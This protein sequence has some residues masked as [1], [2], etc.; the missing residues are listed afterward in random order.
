VK[1]LKK[2]LLSGTLAGVVLAAAGPAMADLTA[3]YEGMVSGTL[4][5]NL[6]GDGMSGMGNYYIGASQFDKNLSTAPHTTQNPAVLF[7][8]F[9][10]DL[11]QE[12]S[13]G[14]YTWT[15]ASLIGAPVGKNGANPYAIEEWQAWRIAE[16]WAE[17]YVK[18]VWNNGTSYN[19]ANAA[20]FQAA[21]WEIIYQ[22][23]SDR[24]VAVALSTYD[25]RSG[26]NQPTKIGFQVTTPSG[27]G[28]TNGSTGTAATA[29]NWL[30]ALNGGPYF[31]MLESIRSYTTQ[32]FVIIGTTSPIPAPG[33]ALLGVIGLSL[34][35]WVK[36]RFA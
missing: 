26:W 22:T 9:C 13:T 30:W 16:L 29:N 12:I 28:W 4:W 7:Y 35:G 6:G 8:G 18:D 15:E 21:L 14:Q 3:R 19:P 31:T 34:V 23:G 1:K 5:G 20:A 25:V 11:A 10:I 32:D 2:L 36:R 17:H 27:G 24:S 33:A